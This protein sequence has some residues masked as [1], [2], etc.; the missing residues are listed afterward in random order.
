M[1]VCVLGIGGG[2]VFRLCFGGGVEW[3]FVGVCGFVYVF[4]W[5]VC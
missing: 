5:L 4:I 2:D 3:V 1:D